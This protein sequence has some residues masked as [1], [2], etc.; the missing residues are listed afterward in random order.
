MSLTGLHLLLTYTCTYE[1]DHCFIW[2]SPAQEG[3]MT[4][5]QVREVY[6][7]AQDL[8]GVEWIYLEGG[9][10]FLVYPIMVRAAREA[11]VLGFRV[12]IVTN[13][14]WAIAVEDAVEWLRPL[15]GVVQSLSVSTDLFHADEVMSVRAGHALAAAERLGIPVDTLICEVPEGVAGYPL[16]PK[17]EPVEGGPVMFKGRAAV[18]LVDGVPRRP[19]HEF[20]EC[21]HE[22]LEDPGRVHV[23]CLGYVHLC[24]GLTMGNLFE[25]PL[26]EM[27]AA[28]APRDHP[29]VGPLLDGGPAALVERYG[30]VHGESYADACHLC[31]EARDAL[32]ERF[33]QILGPGQAY[34]EGLS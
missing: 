19:W 6:R 2:G 26:A 10:P 27:V 13:N 16:Q 12:G 15:A 30:L 28:Y 5:A 8:G 9:E 20:D 14:Y 4:L 1:C 3:T 22:K 24:Q 32:R 31:Y 33:P 23:D 18:K 29:V 7:Q 21:P 11:A 17:G 25:L 34:G